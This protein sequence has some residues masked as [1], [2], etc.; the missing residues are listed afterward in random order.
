MD[1]GSFIISL[2]YELMWG[3]RDKRTI[4]NY[5]DA[6]LNVHQVL[7]QML[8]AMEN[9]DVKATIATVGFLFH[10]KKEDLLR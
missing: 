1:S 2:D 5:G 7:P 6:I 10:E 3:V 4:A 9:Y 8:K